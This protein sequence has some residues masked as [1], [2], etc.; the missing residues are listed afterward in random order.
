[1]AVGLVGLA[2]VIVP[3]APL[4]DGRSPDEARYAE[5]RAQWEAGQEFARAQLTR[6][7]RLVDRDQI[8]DAE[9]GSRLTALAELDPELAVRDLADDAREAQAGL[10]HAREH[11]ARQIRIP[12]PVPPRWRILPPGLHWSPIWD[13]G[14][15]GDLVV[16]GAARNSIHWPIWLSLQLAAVGLLAASLVWRRMSDLVRG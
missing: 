3:R 5:A 10:A 9:L 4:I 6:I 8:G 2:L 13:G 14:F 15:R 1:M 11:Y 7:E 16:G 12:A